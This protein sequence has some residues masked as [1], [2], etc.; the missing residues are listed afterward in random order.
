M[1]CAMNGTTEEYLAEK[2]PVCEEEFTEE[3]GHF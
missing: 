3:T 2:I 1:G